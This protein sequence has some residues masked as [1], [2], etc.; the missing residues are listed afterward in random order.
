MMSTITKFY[1]R[2]EVRQQTPES[3]IQV[4]ES[5]PRNSQEHDYFVLQFP[6]N[7][8]DEDIPHFNLELMSLPLKAAAETY[9][10]TASVGA[11]VKNKHKQE[12][13]LKSEAKNHHGHAVEVQQLSKFKGSEVET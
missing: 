9:K 3:S 1:N 6:N 8:H 13:H 12:Q 7:P 10:R 11:I 4:Y 5:K 2:T